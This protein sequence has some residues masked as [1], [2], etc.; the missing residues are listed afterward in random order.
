[1]RDLAFLIGYLALLYGALLSP[2][3]GLVAAVW[4][5]ALAPYNY[6]Y[7]IAN[8]LPLYLFLLG[9]TVF[10]MFAH[11]EKLRLSLT[12]THWLMSLLILQG[13]ISYVFSIGHSTQAWDDLASLSKIFI[14]CTAISITVRTR[15]HIH[16]LVVAYVL[17][18]GFSGL[19]EGLKVFATAGA[20]IVR[21]IPQLGDNNS[22]GM[23]MLMVAPLA[24]YLYNCLEERWLRYGFLGVSLSCLLVVIGT[25]SRG[26]FIAMLALGMM[27]VIR[28]RRRLRDGLLAIGVVVLVLGVASARWY[29]RID[30]ISSAESDS[31][32]VGRI[33]AW[34]LSWVIAL[35][36]P[37]IGVGFRTMQEPGVWISYIDKFERYY[38]DSPKP[39]EKAG[40]AAHSIVFQVLADLGFPGL[41]IFLGL[42]AIAFRNV[43]KARRLSIA[44]PQLG[45]MRDLTIA[46]ELSL[47]S[48]TVA[49]L[50]LSVNYYESFYLLITFIAL[51]RRLAQESAPEPAVLRTAIGW[52]PGR[53]G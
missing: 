43:R 29:E 48:Y 41:A 2:V 12:S 26:A 51:L 21:G 1:M 34:K 53:V 31:S 20:H 14:I 46:L 52:A 9:I 23:V 42:L 35:D 25:N 16:A 5:A 39:D 45:W 33:T 36:R 38:P 17:G 50:A 44:N 27:F 8:S 3:A 13:A 6:V 40:H 18:L 11:P 15:S 30:T 32:F 47:V 7:G 37:L 28:S 22:F 10:S 49:G 4:M 19:V 24:Y